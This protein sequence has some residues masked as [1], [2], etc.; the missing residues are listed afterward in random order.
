MPVG[1]FRAQRK[2]WS[3]QLMIMLPTEGLQPLRAFLHALGL[4]PRT[5]LSAHNL[6]DDPTHPDD[7]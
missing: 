6:V 3:A 2:I 1:R 4:V 5:T 7:S